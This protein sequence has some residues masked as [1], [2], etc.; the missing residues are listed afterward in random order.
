MSDD[1]INVSQLTRELKDEGI[2]RWTVLRRAWEAPV[3]AVRRLVKPLL[4]TEQKEGRFQFA[5]RHLN[6]TIPQWERVVWSDESPFHIWM[7]KKGQIVWIRT[8]KPNY[9]KR[10]EQMVKHGG[11]GFSVWGCF[12]AHGVGPLLRIHGSMNADWYHGVLTTHAMP[13]MKDRVT[14]SHKKVKRHA[15]VWHFQHDN[16]TPHTA[17]RNKVY[18]QTKET[19]WVG[20]FK[21][22]EWPSN[23]PDLSPIENLWSIVKSEVKSYKTRPK[24]LD[25]LFQRVKSAWDNLPAKTLLK[26]AQSMPKRVDDVI[27]KEGWT[28]EY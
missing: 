15:P 19:E 16:A 27:K 7:P 1:D 22:L 8:D 21:V 23:S 12:H 24:N 14:S 28:I 6:W 17:N 10:L 20:K 4:T 2:S 13:F 11:G 26:L 25:E 5:E 18:L 3:K 9:E